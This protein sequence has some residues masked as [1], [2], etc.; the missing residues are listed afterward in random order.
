V[1]QLY[2]HDVAASVTR[3][4]RQLKAYRHV[5]LAPGASQKVSFILRR[6]DLTFIG[7]GLKPM[8]EPG[9]FRVWI[10]PSAEADGVSGRFTLMA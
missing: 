5:A 1:V 2:V 9:E 7:A 6:S 3:P 4:V 8:V 10:A